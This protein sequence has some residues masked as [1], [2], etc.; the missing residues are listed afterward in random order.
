MTLAR[1]FA[2]TIRTAIRTT[3]RRTLRT[4]LVAASLALPVAPAMADDRAVT[5]ALI[6]AGVSER[7]ARRSLDRG[8]RAAILAFERLLGTRG[9]GRLDADEFPALM[10]VAERAR[11]R[12]GYGIVTDPATGARIGLPRAWLAGR[13]D[14]PTGSAWSSPD[15][16]IA[17]ETFAMD[18]GLDAFER[19][20]RRRGVDV[21]YVAGRERWRVVSGYAPGGRT[22]YARA[23][24]R[25]GGTVGF[26]VT[27]ERA[28]GD[29]LDRVVVAMSSDF[30]VPRRPAPDA[31]AYAPLDQR[32]SIDDGRFDPPVLPRAPDY[33]ALPQ[34]G[35]APR[36]RPFAAPV[37]S[38]A[39]EVARETAPETARE[40][41]RE[42]PRQI[43]REVPREVPRAPAAPA[44]PAAPLALDD[45]ADALALDP[46]RGGEGA[47]L[48]A[49]DDGRAETGVPE[50]ITGLITDEGQSCPTLRGPDGTLYALVGEVPS[51]PPGTLVSVEAVGVDTER[52]SAGRT[53]AIGGLEVR[54]TPR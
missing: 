27:Y 50:T 3:I 17:V 15:G 6:W 37:R 44:R 21:T 12:E 32:P 54:S 28:L 18:R 26:R 34:S 7:V 16:A 30:A 20:E 31:L 19:A 48:G 14:T 38:V 52:C 8:D 29:R 45:D 35:P 5:D 53:V 42:V 36:E 2:D 22:V 4:T 51:L 41:V 10:A 13:A 33:A 23:V 49:P 39:R 43:P 9:D 24:P 1:R 11:A 46:V 25:A 47:A 40:T